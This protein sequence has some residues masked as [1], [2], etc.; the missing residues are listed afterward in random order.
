M[1]AIASSTASVIELQT[2]DEVDLAEREARIERAQRNAY[3]EIGLE[4]RAIRD[5]RL[6]K[7]KR[8]E[9]VSGRYSFETF[10]EYVEARWDLE[11]RRV[12]QLIDAAGVAENLNNC[13]PFLPSRE[14]H[15]RPLLALDNDAD[16]AQV[17]QHVIEKH[18]NSITAKDVEAEVALLQAAKAKDWVELSVWKEL[19]DDQRQALLSVV[20]DREFNKQDN[21]SIEWAQWSWNPVT[22]CKHDCPY[23]YARD[24]ADRFYPQKFEPSLYA[25]RL[26]APANT[27]VPAKADTDI[28]FKNVFVCSMA[29]LFGRWVP[30]EWI[31]A[32]LKSV[33]DNPQWNFLFLTK[34]P[35]RLVEFEF[36]ENAWIGTTVDCQ[37]RVKAAEEAFAKV[38]ASVKWLSVEPM[39]EPLEF[40]RLDLFQWIVIGGSSRSTETPEWRVPF[41]WWMPLHLKA[42]SIGLTVYHKDNLMTERER[43]Y[44]TRPHADPKASPAVF[45]YLKQK[46]KADIEL[47]EAG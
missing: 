29:D 42:K 14:S 18:G 39:T 8:T 9:A 17:W 21:S 33:R 38:K 23:C 10:E 20:G 11:Y 12:L 25:N 6:Y 46:T 47:G 16:R 36:P 15:V 5:K 40:S 7:T 2:K 32:V 37:A 26:T 4:L 27:K 34:F 3:Y 31:E 44:P 43:G 22:G 19:P 1:S 30:R 13:S 45:H 35:K 24:I 41:D 28:A